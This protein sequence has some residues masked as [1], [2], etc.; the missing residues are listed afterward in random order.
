MSR[1]FILNEIK[2]VREKIN[3]LNMQNNK[4]YNDIIA[5]YQSYMLEHPVFIASEHG[6]FWP[7]NILF[8]KNKNQIQVIDWESYKENGSPLYDL[9]FFIIQ[10][11][12]A[13]RIDIKDF[14]DNYRNEYRYR[15]F[16]D[17]ID[18]HFGFKIDMSIVLP[19]VLLRFTIDRNI[20]HGFHEKDVKRNYEM[21]DSLESK[22][23][24]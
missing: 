7:G 20:E 23:I 15:E 22:H 13:N 6:D 10:L 1:E 5:N 24:I 4:K 12:I 14:V 16:L 2:N 9:V 17:M 19:F 21:L 3:I 18:D 8:D 11:N